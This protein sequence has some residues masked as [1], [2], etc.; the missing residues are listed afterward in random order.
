[1]VTDPI[2][3]MITRLL[4]AG[5]AQHTEARMPFSAMKKTILDILSREG[6]VGK[7]SESKSMPRELVVAIKY[8]H[9]TPR[10]S[11][12]ARVSKP[13]RRVYMGVNNIRKV[14]YGYGL[15]LL[16]T[17]KGVMTDKE[18]KKEQ[19]GGEALFKIW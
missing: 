4:N 5:R 2:G 3:D 18:A 14:R 15:L 17:P 11:G 19:V 8:E 1:M 16:S 9:K 12:A 6:F 13:S 7:V 10:I